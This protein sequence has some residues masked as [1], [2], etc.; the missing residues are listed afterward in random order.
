MR[1]QAKNAAYVAVG[2]ADV[3]IEKV[4]ETVESVPRLAKRAGKVLGDMEKRGQRVVNRSKAKRKSTAAMR[5]TRARRPASTGRSATR[6]RARARTAGTR[7]STGTA[8]RRS[9]A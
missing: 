7:R 5:K 4:R 2:T 3:T 9:R 8:A 6:T 1:K